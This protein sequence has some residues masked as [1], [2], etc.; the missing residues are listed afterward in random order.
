M[1]GLIICPHC[2]GE[3]QIDQVLSAQLSEQIRTEFETEFAIKVRKLA[4]ERG[5]ITELSK[6]LERQE[7]ELESRVKDSVERERSQLIAKA[8][9]EAQ[10]ALTLEMKDRDE[11]LRRA[12]E[13]LK[14]LK[15]QELELHKQKR[16]MEERA[17]NQELE[18]ARRIDAERKSIRSQAFKQLEQQNQFKQ[19]ED[20]LL[21]DTMRKQIA[22]LQRKIEQGSQQVQG[23]VQEIVLENLLAAQFPGDLIEPVAKGARGGDVIQR[24]IDFSGRE[25]GTI[26]W[27][28]KRTKNW[29]DQWLSK[30]IDDQ[31]SARASCA[32]IVSAVVPPSVE[33]FGELNGVWVATWTCAR[34]IAIA[35]RRVVVET[36]QARTAMQGQ[37]GKQERVYEYLSGSEFRNRVRGLVEPYIEMQADLESEKRAYNKHWN[38]RQK[39]LDRA[40]ASTTGLYGDLQGI[41]GS[42]LQEIE[43]MDLLALEEMDIAAC[44][45]AT[46]NNQSP[47]ITP[48]S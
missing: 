3:F 25:C 17:E 34:S 33:Y 8:R 41:I 6:R 48:D 1:S 43:G 46:N 44:G 42:G 16:E 11:Q 18:I 40:I 2:Q 39:Q 24:V 15:A 28:S 30:A 26:L 47:T 9:A 32:C 12:H 36:S 35:L 14:S 31:Q 4:E 5:K 37:L 23:E 45:L 27:E 19:E 38:K 21:I 10:A 22:D 29:S 7:E 20:K 13:E